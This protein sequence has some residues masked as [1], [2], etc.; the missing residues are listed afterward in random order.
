MIREVIA[1]LAEG[2]DLSPEEATLAMQ[3][4]MD[5][6]A[7]PA[8]VGAFL[9]GLRL[10]GE[11]PSEIAAFARVMRHKATP[12]RVPVEV[13]LDTCGTGG[14]RVGTFNISTAAALVAAGAG[15]HVAKHGNR[16]VS[17]RS[18]SADVLEKLGVN[19]NADVPTVERCVCEAR[20]GFL[21]APILHGAMKHAI[22][23]RRE[24]GIRTV[25]NI[26]GPLTN[27]AGA[28]HQLLGVFRRDLT[29]VMARAL[30]ELGSR[31]ALVVCGLDGLDEISTASPTQVTELHEGSVRTYELDARALGFP[32]ARRED[33]LVSSVEESAAV[34]RGV[35]D[36]KR[37][38]ARDI[39]VLNAAAALLAAEAVA[40]MT[41]GIARATQV[42]D[43]GAAR[44]A[45]ERLIS[46]SN[47]G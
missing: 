6:H 21:F 13:V 28:R 38:P 30:H 19:V 35:L 36:G 14:D 43:S 46:I 4:I 2:R 37:G 40:D 12:I 45:L 47:S 18:G 9:M 24:M 10:K 15:V 42:L 8:Q 23:P 27:P 33:L 25:F 26:L 44:D 39:V 16:S 32:A 7:T 20:I 11:K 3:E 22:G 29:E 31:R 34:I 1:M 17:S 41:D 5:G